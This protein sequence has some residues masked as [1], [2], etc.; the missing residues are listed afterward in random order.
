MPWWGWLLVSVLGLGWLC[1]IWILF[2]LSRIR[3]WD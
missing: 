1:V 3:L 2:I